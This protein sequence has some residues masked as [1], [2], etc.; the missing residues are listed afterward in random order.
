MLSP[1]DPTGSNAEGPYT[2]WVGSFQPEALGLVQ[3]F[4]RVVLSIVRASFESPPIRFGNFIIRYSL[5]V[6]MALLFVPD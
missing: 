1:D 5:T 4:F 2:R 6:T 3:D